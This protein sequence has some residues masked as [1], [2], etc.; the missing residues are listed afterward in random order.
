MRLLDLRSV[1]ILSLKQI[2]T[3]LRLKIQENKGITKA[4]AI[5]HERIKKSFSADLDIIGWGYHIGRRF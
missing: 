3:R 2:E 5:I 4:A 1:Q